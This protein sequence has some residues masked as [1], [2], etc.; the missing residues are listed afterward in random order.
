MREVAAF[1]GTEIVTTD[2]PRYDWR[3]PYH[4]LL[5]MSWGSFL[6]GVLGYFLALNAVFGTLYAL[7]PASVA[8]LSPGR[9]DDAFFFSVETFGTVGYGAMAPQTS[10]SHLV[11]T[12]EIFLGLLSTAVLTGLIFVRFARPRANMEFS[13]QITIAPHD[14]VPTLSLRLGNHRSGTL[15]HADASLTLIR[16]HQ[17]LEGHVMWRVHD[18]PLMRSRVQALSLAWTLRHA[19]DAASPLHGLSVEQLIEMD[20]Q[21][22]VSITGTDATLA[23]PVHA[24]RAY[25]PA[26]LL[27]GFR[28]ADVMTVDGRGRT[29]IELARLHEVLP[30]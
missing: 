21:F 14:G 22:V 27:W 1:G 20:A 29:R 24:V 30:A 25:E 17:T 18:L 16:R 23:A 11:A 12:A 3:D 15:F 13:R 10:Y 28:F 9:W 4:A 26:D 8:N 7:R 6:L 5:A 2:A 19:I